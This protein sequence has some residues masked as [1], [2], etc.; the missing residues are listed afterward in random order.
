MKDVSETVGV[1]PYVLKSWERKFP[2]LKPAKNKSGKRL[3]KPGDIDLI[4]KIRDWI[5]QGMSDLDVLQMLEGQDATLPDDGGTPA[6]SHEPE[7]EI[8][9]STTKAQEI[10]IAEIRRDLEELLGLLE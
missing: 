7:V 5:V 8:P 1:S 9:R 3:Y 10:R 6:A 4:V 2:A